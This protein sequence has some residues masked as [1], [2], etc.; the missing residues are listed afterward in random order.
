M[1]RQKTMDILLRPMQTG[2][3]IGTANLY[4]YKSKNHKCVSLQQIPEWLQNANCKCGKKA[5]FLLEDLSVICPECVLEVTKS[6]DSTLTM[7]SDLSVPLTIGVIK[8]QS[9]EWSTDDGNK[10]YRVHGKNMV[11]EGDESEFIDRMKDSLVNNTNAEF[12]A[13]YDKETKIMTILL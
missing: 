5:K 9:F 6:C 2:K 7:K 12:R 8:R 4:E 1:Y 13:E 11:I 10:W 3:P